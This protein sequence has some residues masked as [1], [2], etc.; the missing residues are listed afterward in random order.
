MFLQ[1]TTVTAT[2]NNEF[3]QSV[4]VASSGDDNIVGDVIDLDDG[5]NTITVTV[6]AQNGDIGFYAISITRTPASDRH[7]TCRI[8]F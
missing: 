8:K 7:A 5:L 4:V 3:A 6:T 2:A 1:Q